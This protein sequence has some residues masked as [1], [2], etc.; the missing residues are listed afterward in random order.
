MTLQAFFIPA[1]VGQRFCLL[2]EPPAGV[3]VRGAIV[4]L[5]AFAE[6]MNCARG[7]VARQARDLAAVGFRVLQIDLFGC[8]DSSGD[9]AEASWSQWLTDARLACDFV[10]GPAPLWLWGL[11]A[12]ALLA[13]ETASSAANVTGL[14]LWQ[15]AFDGAQILR[16]FLRL[17][18]AGA[19]LGGGHGSL[20]GLKARLAAGDTLE[21]G[22]YG[23]S[24]RLAAELETAGWPA[25]APTIRLIGCEMGDGSTLSP[26][27]S[28]QMTTWQAAG[29]AVELRPVAA[30]HFW[31]A[32]GHE[33]APALRQTTLALLGGAHR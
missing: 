7:I 31:L 6:E 32:P 30:P 16:H 28:R 12:G 25:L 14:L 19:A 3:P 8:G 1:E 29:H 13:A 9:F 2:H 10:A 24:P 22:G 15:P 21:I 5:H 4:H 18:V 26:A 33:D 27:L 20:A 23:L 11:R 17:H